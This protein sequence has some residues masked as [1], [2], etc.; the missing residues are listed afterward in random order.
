MQRNRIFYE[1]VTFGLA[2]QT[3]A[4]YVMKSCLR[5]YRL[6]YKLNEDTDYVCLE[7]YYIP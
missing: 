5:V 1:N 4:E 7:H 6:D 3:I 2:H